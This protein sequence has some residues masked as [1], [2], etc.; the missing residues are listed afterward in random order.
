MKSTKEAQWDVG[1]V[2]LISPEALTNIVAAVA[3]IAVVI[4]QD[5]KILAVLSNPFH[6]VLTDLPAWEGRD[7]RGLLTVESV[8]KFD[9]ALGEASVK[10]APPRA[11]ELNH[12]D[13]T[14]S[15]EFPV[16]YTL[17]LLSS[18]GAMLMM[19]RD[20]RPIADLQQQLVNAQIAVERD[21]EKQRGFDTRFRVLMHATH[22]P[23][24]FIT[25]GTG[26]IDEV[27]GA[28]ASLFGRT[29]E[30]LK[31]ADFAELFDA[32]NQS[33]LNADLAAAALS[34]D[35]SSTLALTL[36]RKD[37]KVSVQPS[38]FRAAGVRM[39]LC[40]LSVADPAPSTED[41]A[42]SRFA[43]LFRRG[44]DAIVFTSAD[45]TIL[46][47]NDSFLALVDAN[48]EDSLRGQSL[49]DYLDW[50]A[51]EQKALLENI[52]RS[53]RI[54]SYSTRLRG[55]F[56]SRSPVE[57]SATRL[58]GAG[59]S[60]FAF[61]I[62]DA[63][64]AETARGMAE[65]SNEKTPQDR[66][67]VVDLVGS[68]SLK[69]IVADTTD[70]IEKMCIETALELTGNNRAAAAEMLGLSRQSLYVK[71]RKFDLLGKPDAD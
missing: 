20:L 66:T 62:R 1:A 11:T 35:G 2:P 7:V 15:A 59:G 40:R 58:T 56:D 33:E 19:G 9:R 5:A 6:G 50:G 24:A 44:P 26:R 36:K 42:D 53:G 22:D 64:R 31:G 43:A 48:E 12:K 67:S 29:A 14:T 32:Q 37:R 3:D 41:A 60:A 65:A 49:S 23:V 54:S 27:N 17:H 63:A 57:L 55:K 46:T 38:F 52:T 21:Y 51:I 39:L 10:G 4:D 8:S 71:L 30:E 69:E 34:D 47:V 28:A 25:V 18:D 45:G 68:T 70:V 13:P 61:V 16:S